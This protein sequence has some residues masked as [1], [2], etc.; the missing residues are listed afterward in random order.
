MLEGLITLAANGEY[1]A[2]LDATV[3]LDPSMVLLSG[4]Q[5]IGD[6][7]FQWQEQGSWGCPGDAG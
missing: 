6:D 5:Q 7:R 2:L 4:A 1:Q 3:P